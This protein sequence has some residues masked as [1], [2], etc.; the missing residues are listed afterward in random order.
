MALCVLCLLGLFSILQ[1]LQAERDKELNGRF[2]TRKVRD[3]MASP[4]RVMKRLRKGKEKSVRDPLLEDDD[5]AE[6]R[7]D[8]EEEDV[9][10]RHPGRRKPARNVSRRH[11]AGWLHFKPFSQSDCY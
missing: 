5:A 8:D 1:E 10:D 7:D 11:D 2:K 9:D 4:A 6:L 3:G